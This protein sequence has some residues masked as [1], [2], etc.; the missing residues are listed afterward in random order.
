[1]YVTNYTMCPTNNRMFCNNLSVFLI[2][3]MFSTLKI[4]Y[5]VLLHICCGWGL[6]GAIYWS[7]ITLLS[8]WCLN[9]RYVSTSDKKCLPPIEKEQETR[10][11][12]VSQTISRTRSVDMIL[13]HWAVPICH[14][15]YWTITSGF[16]LEHM[17]TEIS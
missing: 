17:F 2:S 16:G 12:F 10:P 3:P 5:I 1:M 4:T 9:M 7:S 15:C 13:W 11:T 8:L 14:R 6:A